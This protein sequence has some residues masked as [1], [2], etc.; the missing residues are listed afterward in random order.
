MAIGTA[1]TYRKLRYSVIAILLIH[2]I[3]RKFTEGP[4]IF[5]DLFLYNAIAVGVAV[6]AFVA[7]TFNDHFARLSIA[8]AI[9]LWAIGS[10]STTWNSFFDYQV[11]PNISDLCYIGFYPLLLFGLIRA[12]TAKRQF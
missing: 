1:R 3:L 8:A 5:G 12:L 9:F 10:I 4:S 7:P 11:W 6:V 2:L